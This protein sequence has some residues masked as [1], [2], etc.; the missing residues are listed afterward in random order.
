[1]DENLL[2]LFPTPVWMVENLIS[3][4]E[5]EEIANHIL[6]VKDSIPGKGES[7]WF[8][9]KNSPQNSFDTDYKN[10]IF[11]NLLTKINEQALEY[12]KVL[13]FEE[14]RIKTREWWWNV[15]KKENFQEYHGHVPYYFSGVY[16]CKAPEGSSPITF[17]HPNF[18]HF[19]PN[20]ERNQYNSSSKAIL[21][22]E[23]NLIIFPSDFIHCVAPGTN[24]EPRITISFNYG[25]IV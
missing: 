13:K 18:N 12:A 5:N 9:G 10:P 15:Y 23:R 25:G 16:F 17:R 24:E 19:V 8:S 2:L 22:V 3:E 1:M 21:A 4:K 7:V 11:N 6:S 20:Y 14:S